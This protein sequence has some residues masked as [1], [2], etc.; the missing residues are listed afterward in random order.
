MLIC[1]E[2]LSGMNNDLVY[3]TGPPCWEETEPAADAKRG[4]CI[5]VVD[6]S[7][8]FASAQK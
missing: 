8:E 7:Y 1:N 6:L 3:N 4:V 2:F 5:I